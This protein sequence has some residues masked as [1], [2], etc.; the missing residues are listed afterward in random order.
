MISPFRD[1]S[2]LLLI[3]LVAYLL[4]L[5][6]LLIAVFVVAVEAARATPLSS[7]LVFFQKGFRQLIA[8]D[9][10]SK[11]CSYPP[12]HCAV[13]APVDHHLSTLSSLTFLHCDTIYFVSTLAYHCNSLISNRLHAVDVD[14]H[15]LQQ[16]DKSAERVAFS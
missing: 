6:L 12:L 4:L 3:N 10:V 2:L 9:V 8:R 1:R 16:S 5:L 15:H 14:F 11:L 7:L 13:C